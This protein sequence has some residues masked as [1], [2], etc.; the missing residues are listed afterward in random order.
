MPQPVRVNKRHQATVKSTSVRT[1]GVAPTF[2]L[3]GSRQALDGATWDEHYKRAK[4]KFAQ[5]V[6]IEDPL[7][8]RVARAVMLDPRLQAQLASSGTSA[9]EYHQRLISDPGLLARVVEE[10]R[11]PAWVETALAISQLDPQLTSKV[12]PLGRVGT[13]PTALGFHAAQ[14]LINKIPGGWVPRT[15]A[16]VLAWQAVAPEE[17]VEAARPELAQVI[18]LYEAGQQL[19][20]LDNQRTDGMTPQ[21]AAQLNQQVAKQLQR[22]QT[23]AEET[24]RAPGVTMRDR[25]GEVMGQLGDRFGKQFL[26]P[27]IHAIPTSKK[28]L[29]GQDVSGQEQAQ[30]LGDVAGASY[31]YPRILAAGRTPP[32]VGAQLLKLPPTTTAGELGALARRVPGMLSA[33]ARAAP[34]AAL[35]AAAPGAAYEGYHRSFTPEGQDL[36]AAQTYAIDKALR[37]GDW[38]ERLGQTGEALGSLA[39]GD[40]GPAS[41]ALGREMLRLPFVGVKDPFQIEREA[42]ERAAQFP[43]HKIEATKGFRA[44]FPA[45]GPGQ[46]DDLASA[47]AYRRWRTLDRRDLPNTQA[48]VQAVPAVVAAWKD[49]GYDLDDKQVENFKRVVELTGLQPAIN[50]LFTA[51]YRKSTDPASVQHGFNVLKADV[52][53]NIPQFA[54][55]KEPKWLT[56]AE[57]KVPEQP[58]LPESEVAFRAAEA[59][60]AARRPGELAYRRAVA[61][62]QAAREAGIAQRAADVKAQSKATWDRLRAE[63]GPDIAKGPVDRGI[64]WAGMPHAGREEVAAAPTFT[65]QIE[66]KP[67]PQWAPPAYMVAEDQR[68]TELWNERLGLKKDWVPPHQSMAKW[69]KGG[70][71]TPAAPAPTAP[72]TTPAVQPV[73]VAQNRQPPVGRP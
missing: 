3:L 5:E 34:V 57:E 48:D 33:G 8:E 32:A 66:A 43:Q 70:P 56:G 64:P 27:L 17:R 31:A 71:A 45:L 46:I 26:H 18:D 63:Y 53:E 62:R 54:Y 42:E 22:V 49:Q 25:A 6:K 29:F 73:A 72:A 40:V 52:P 58:K 21:Q 7:L 20:A 47:A 50:G 23:L 11:G 14:P 51:D 65:P 68:Q 4:A 41:A 69:I 10:Q 59:E 36:Q 35:L 39:S 2:N 24:P 61:E 30:M 12:S 16:E 28:T 55:T 44:M 38:R 19:K 37:S 60:K 15:V 1:P 9:D 13:A 67:D